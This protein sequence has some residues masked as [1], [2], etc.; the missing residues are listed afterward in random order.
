MPADF[1]PNRDAAIKA[2]A[3]AFVDHV[4][5]VD[6]DNPLHKKWT[7]QKPGTTHFAC[8]IALVDTGT[9]IVTGD[10]GDIILHFNWYPLGK[11]SVFGVGVGI[12][13]GYI[14]EKLSRSMEE[15]FIEPKGELL[16]EWLADEIANADEDDPEVKK[17]LLEMQEEHNEGAFDDVN[18]D[19]SA[20]EAFSYISAHDVTDC[21]YP[22]LQ[23]FTERFYIMIEVLRHFVAAMPETST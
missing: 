7:F 20:R 18:G 3:N 6:S 8:D 2:T 14:Y 1:K 4:V 13:Y 10:L 23:A 19:F 21:Y 17:K 22:P 12:D 5:T 16:T 11:K 9:I 15:Y